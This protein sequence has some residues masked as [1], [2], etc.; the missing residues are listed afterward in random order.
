LNREEKAS[1]VK[2][3]ADKFK[4]ANLA[5]ASDYRGLP[6]SL[7]EELRGQLRECGAEVKVA[8]NTLLKR[9]V[10]GTDFES[11]S[12]GFK[13]TTAVTLSYEDPVGAAKAISKFS[14]EHDEVN[15]KIAVLDGKILDENDL[16]ALSKL[17]PKEILLAQTLAM[18]NAVPTSF[19]RV[20]SAVPTN[21]LYLLN[22]IKEKKEDN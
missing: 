20:L 8:K 21:L 7:F 6:V 3:F 1:V 22:A 14:D 10:D 5:I 4:K 2:E 16:K 18:M 19:V 9:A 17:P 15:I 13:G 12:E 11:L